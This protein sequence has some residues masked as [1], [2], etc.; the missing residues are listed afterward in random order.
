MAVLESNTGQ[1]RPNT[2]INTEAPE[3]EG[4]KRRKGETASSIMQGGQDT[5]EL[6]GTR[7]AEAKGFA[8]MIEA[9]EADNKVTATTGDTKT[10]LQDM[11][12]GSGTTA[13]DSGKINTLLEQAGL[14]KEVKQSILATAK[15]ERPDPSTYLSQE[16]IKN[17]VANF[18]NG[19]TKI[20]AVP[21]KGVE[22]IGL[23]TF[24]MPKSV[25]DKMIMEA[26]G[27]IRVLENL[28]ALESG[29]LG[30]SPV[31]VDIPYPKNIRVPSGNEAGAFDGYWVPGGYTAGGIIEAVIDPVDPSSYIVSNI[32]E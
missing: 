22:G 29:Q 27:D 3:I 15:G 21:P 23:G 9:P 5:L 17:H 12:G 24:V 10:D 4:W 31:R 18:E 25:A 1:T 7:D 13:I 14:T 26:N 30:Y 20:K 19:V 8:T 32:F 2:G 6:E 11:E 16:Y 28:L